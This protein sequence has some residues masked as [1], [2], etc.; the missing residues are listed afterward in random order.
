MLYSLYAVL[1]AIGSPL[2][3]VANRLH[4]EAVQPVRVGESYSAE[5][6]LSEANVPSNASPAFCAPALRFPSRP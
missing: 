6:A 4:G 5:P 1:Q 2:G 3:P